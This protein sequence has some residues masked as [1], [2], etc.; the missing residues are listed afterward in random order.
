MEYLPPPLFERTYFLNN[1]LSILQF[2]VVYFLAWTDLKAQDIVATYS[3][4]KEKFWMFM[5]IKCKE[6]DEIIVGRWL[7]KTAEERT[8]SV[9]V[10]VDTINFNNVVRLG[11]DYDM[12]FVFKA[13]NLADEFYSISCG[14]EQLLLRES[15]IQPKEVK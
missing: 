7:N 8:Y 15:A 11:I 10:Q 4:E 6:N 3:K 9:S 12:F 2:Y 14:T 13:H 5:V 1:P